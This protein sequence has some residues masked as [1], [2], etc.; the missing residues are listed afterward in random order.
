MLSRDSENFC[1]KPRTTISENFIFVG[2]Y[3]EYQ[4]II[5]VVICS[6][7]LLMNSSPILRCLYELV[8]CW[9]TLLAYIFIR[10]QT[11]EIV[12]SSCCSASLDSA[13]LWKKRR[14]KSNFFILKIYS[15]HSCKR[16]TLEEINSPG[17]KKVRLSREYC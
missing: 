10:S 16:K 13:P 17:P 12:F 15:L 8:K 1:Y 5:S 3:G 7:N 6:K 9:N 4:I 11:I 14:C 2:K